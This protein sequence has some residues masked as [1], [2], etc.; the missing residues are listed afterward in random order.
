M[1]KVIIHPGQMKSSTT[2]IQS[3]MSTNRDNLAKQG[4]VYPG[5]RNSQQYACYGLAGNDIPWIKNWQVYK[6]YAEELVGEVQSNRCNCDVLI[7]AEAL[8]SMSEQGVVKFL[9]AI[10]GA[11]QVVFTLRNLHRT[12]PSAWQQTLKKGN[13]QS[14][15]EYFDNLKKAREARLGPW[16]TYSYSSNIE[17]WAKYVDVKCI[18][19]P[20]R[21]DDH[22]L[23]WALFSRAIGLQDSSAFMVP[24]KK[25]NSSMS[26]E[27]AQILRA[28][29]SVARSL[30]QNPKKLCHYYYKRFIRESDM[31]GPSIRPPIEYRESLCEWDSEE[32]NKVLSLGVDIIGDP[33]LASYQG[34]WLTYAQEYDELS[35]STLQAAKNFINF[36]SSSDICKPN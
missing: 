25:S 5:R 30:G 31:D 26:M 27:S 1:G 15:S 22:H 36:Y 28:I 12:F 13:N 20:D 19:L 11:D 21:S 4:V 35:A 6:K 10:G 14:V 16:R 33:D 9:E 18:I 29:A 3:I 24:S 17:V 32:L 7:S 34:G 2:F 23:P 8:S